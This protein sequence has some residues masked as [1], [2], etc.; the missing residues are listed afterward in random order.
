MSKIIATYEGIFD[1]Y[2][3][4]SNIKIQIISVPKQKNKIVMTGQG[5]LKNINGSLLSVKKLIHDEKS[6]GWDLKPT[7]MYGASIAYQS[8]GSYQGGP[9]HNFKNHIALFSKDEKHIDK[10]LKF[11]EKHITKKKV[12]RTKRKSKRRTRKSKKKKNNNS[13]YFEYKSGNSRKFWRIVKN[14]NKI[15]THYGKFGTLGQMTTKDYGSKADSEY[16]KLI[17][18]KKKKGYV[19]KN[20]FGDKNPKPP[21]SI[22]REY[23]KICNKA[24]KDIKL[25]PAR[26]NFDCEGIL[27]HSDSEI[28]WMTGWNKDALKNK[29]FDWDKLNEHDKTRRKRKKT[30]KGNG[31]KWSPKPGYELSP[32]MLKCLRKPWQG[33]VP[34]KN[35]KNKIYECHMFVDRSKPFVLSGTNKAPKIQLDHYDACYE[36]MYKDCEKKTDPK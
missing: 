28:K 27:D 5:S 14:G 16:D 34:K 4:K 7:K 29:E 6:L 23:M 30:Q 2:M 32:E 9:M 17:Q 1:V 35:T 18:S 26:R 36:A 33:S 11:L 24:E 15:T 10:L 13:A 31:K 20:D 25:N 3:K 12:R 21:S 8:R 19:E 22:K